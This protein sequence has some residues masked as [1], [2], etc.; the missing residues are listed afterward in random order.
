MHPYA[1]SQVEESSNTPRQIEC[2][3]CTLL[4]P[5]DAG[6]CQICHYFFATNKQAEKMEHAHQDQWNSTPHGNNNS[7]YKHHQNGTNLS[8]HNNSTADAQNTSSGHGLNGILT[9][10]EALRIALT[11]S[12]SKPTQHDNTLNISRNNPNRNI[13]NYN[14]NSLYNY[15]PDNINYQYIQH[16]ET[17]NLYKK[18]AGIPD[19]IDELEA[20]E[21]M[22]ALEISKHNVKIKDKNVQENILGNYNSH[23]WVDCDE[24]EYIN[25]KTNYNVKFNMHM[26]YNVAI[27]V[28]GK[29]GVGKS[30]LIKTMTGNRFIKTSAKYQ[31]CTKECEFYLND[32]ILWIDTKGALDVDQQ[33]QHTL[34]NIQR[35]C[36]ENNIRTLK[37]IW[38]IDKSVRYDGQ[39]DKEAQS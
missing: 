30:S 20:W 21:L 38:C 11:L 8:L 35:K 31:S 19:D 37:F 39:F 7:A 1:H 32:G 3:K 5:F 28:F 33:S 6:R 13:S 10:D 29:T 27:L 16:K 36:Y 4:N 22:Q 12:Q 2:P 9:D 14:N 25:N 18:P 17:E 34:K 24:Q 15:K 26:N 23:D